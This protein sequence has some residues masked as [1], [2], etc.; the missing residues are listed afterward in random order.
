[1]RMRLAT[2]YDFQAAYADINCASRRGEVVTTDE[3]PDHRSA[4]GLKNTKEKSVHHIH[5][6]QE[7][8]ETDQHEYHVAVDWEVCKK[9]ICGNRRAAKTCTLTERATFEI[10]L[11]T[12]VVGSS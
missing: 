10:A 5:T 4:R 8:M 7:Q 11:Q 6:E 3:F 1:M 9:V 12:N 2:K